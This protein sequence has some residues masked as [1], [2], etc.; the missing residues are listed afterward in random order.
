MS[1]TT[2]SIYPLPLSTPPLIKTLVI[3][4]HLV[5]SIKVPIS[6]QPSQ[7]RYVRKYNFFGDHHKDNQDPAGCKDKTVVGELWLH[8][9]NIQVSQLKKII[10]WT[11]MFILTKILILIHYTIQNI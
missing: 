10:V 5:T 7:N 11:N 4:L 9:L 1:F 8:I 3:I 6:A 2:I